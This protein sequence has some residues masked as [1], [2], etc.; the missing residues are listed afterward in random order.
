MTRIIKNSDLDGQL[1][2]E[3]VSEQALSFYRLSRGLASDELLRAGQE[4]DGIINEA[5]KTADSFIVQAKDLHQ[6]MEER[7]AVERKKG[8]DKGYQEGLAEASQVLTAAEAHRE[9]LLTEAEPEV[10]QMV[11]QIIEKILGDA[12]QEGAIV[13]IVKQAL[14]ES[15]GERVTL[16]VNPEDFEN[17]KK[18][19][20]ELLEQFNNLKSMSTISDEHIQRGSCAL[21]TEVGTIDAQLSTQLEA[22]KKSLGLDK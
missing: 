3:T 2:V 20:K 22:I 6:K 21:D 18:A 11:Y 15:V 1:K 14:K 9:K 12:I 8:F 5:Q 4:A 13:S 16:R 7:V 17:V 10:V 19:E